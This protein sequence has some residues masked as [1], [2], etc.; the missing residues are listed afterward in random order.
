MS[1]SILGTWNVW[2]FCWMLVQDGPTHIFTPIRIGV[3]FLNPGFVNR[4]W[5]ECSFRKNHPGGFF[6]VFE[7]WH[8]WHQNLLNCFF[9]PKNPQGPSNGRVNEPVWRRGVFGSS[10][11]CHF[12]GGNRILRVDSTWLNRYVWKS[13]SPTHSIHGTGIFTYMNGW[14]FMVFM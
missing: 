13:P 1:T 6:V 4:R 9:H 5:N 12:W 2:W 11:G 3:F 8:I 14:F 7:F 10:E